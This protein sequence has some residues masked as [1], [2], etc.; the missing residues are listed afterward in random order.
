METKTATFLYLRGNRI[1]SGSGESSDRALSSAI[2]TI[3]N[4]PYP[5]VDI[6]R[7]PDIEPIRVPHPDELKDKVGYIG[8]LTAHTET[9]AISLC[10]G[11]ILNSLNKFSLFQFI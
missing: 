4:S 8:P 9:L 5:H 6:N 11:Y 10:S 1:P 3:W 7:E 2:N